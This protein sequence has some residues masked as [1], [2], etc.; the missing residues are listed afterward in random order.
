AVVAAL[1][2]VVEQPV[3]RVPVTLVVLGR[4][5]PALGGDRVR[6]SRS[7]LVAEALD[8]VAGLA[9]RGIC[10]GAGQTGADDGHV[11]LPPAGGVDQV[12]IELALLPLLSDRPRGR[13]RVGDRLALAVEALDQA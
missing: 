1:N 4:V 6:P 5:D 7:V 3:G 9:E 10:R 11:Q 2:G 12:S 13:G 8:V